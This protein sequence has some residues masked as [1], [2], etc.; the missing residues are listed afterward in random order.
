MFK[1]AKQDARFWDQF[2]EQMML[3]ATLPG[4][5]LDGLPPNMTT[6]GAYLV[7]ESPGTNQDQV[8]AALDLLLHQENDLPVRLTGRAGFADTPT[9]SEL[10]VS[11]T[12]A[13][14]SDAFGVTG[15]D[16]QQVTM[17]LDV[18]TINKPATGD[19]LAAA[20]PTSAVPTIGLGIS[21]NMV[22]GGR[23]VMIAGKVE[24]NIAT[25]T[26]MKVALRGELSSL[27]SL[28][29]VRFANRMS[30]LGA[31]DIN[32][33]ALPN[34]EI[35]DLVINIAPLGGD[36]QLG[37]ED[38]IGLKGELYV[39]DRFLA[40][41]DGSIDR[42]G[43]VPKIRLTAWTHEIELG[44]LSVSDVHIDIQMTQSADDF[45]IVKGSVAV[46]GASHSVDIHLAADKMHYRITTEVDG[47][48]MV[49]YAFESQMTGTPYW[50]FHATVRNDAS[51]HL[52]QNVASGARDW[53]TEA[54]A[55][56]KKAQSAL[57]AA[58]AEVN[59]L[60][61]ERATAIAEAQKEFDEFEAKLEKA[62]KS[63]A[64]LRSRLDSWIRSE[65][66]AWSRYRSAVNSRKAA[67]WYQYAG[68][69]AVE[70]SRYATYIGIRSGRYAVQGSLKAA[71]VVLREVKEAASSTL[72]LA[73]PEM[74][75]EVLRIN[76]E[77]A[78][79]TAGLQIAK[80]AVTAAESVSTETA[81]AIA[82]AAEHHDDLFMIDRIHFSGT[83]SAAIVN[84]EFDLK[85]DCRLL[86]K[87]KKIDIDIS[88]SDFSP[89]QLM[90]RLIDEIRS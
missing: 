39:N 43:I 79:M 82:L 75:P 81:E 88:L 23:D 30:G 50:T 32:E 4:I 9:G 66:T 28:D 71:E 45:F 60:K 31:V 90:E 62:E 78:I 72:D 47:L 59:T 85:I 22:I 74:N 3:R 35:R 49:D 21:A 48:G 14:I 16:L 15:L 41:V 68:R 20:D 11:A 83:L 40:K 54:T 2:R 34:F 8:Y 69:R 77:L 56:F 52:E 38:G 63:V 37:I 53:A 10:R 58:Q 19:K 27:S 76:A 64:T 33:S 26:P 57:D 18:D 12:A 61:Q 80:A 36:T 89:E 44:A 86:N 6:G 70:V 55:S 7:W 17:L 5:N 84:N 65:R 51:T 73:G 1:Q 87:A 46:L 67:K 29:L 42:T 24:L 13:N 25:G